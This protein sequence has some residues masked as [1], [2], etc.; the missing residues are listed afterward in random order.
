M[1]SLKEGFEAI[2]ILYNYEKQLKQEKA[3]EKAIEVSKQWNV[4]EDISA[5]HD[6]VS[7]YNSGDL[8]FISYFMYELK[9]EMKGEY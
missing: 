1:S 8:L 7:V 2:T 3:K 6:I 4:G 9:K 5:A